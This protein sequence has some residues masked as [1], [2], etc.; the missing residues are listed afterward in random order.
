MQVIGVGSAVGTAAGGLLFELG[1]QTALGGW[2]MPF[3]V[4]AIGTIALR[5]LLHAL[6]GKAADSPEVCTLSPPPQLY[7]STAAIVSPTPPHPGGERTKRG[8]SWR[9]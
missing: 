4:S 6:P 3:V 1:E 8:E 5:P 7:C 9:M 2:R